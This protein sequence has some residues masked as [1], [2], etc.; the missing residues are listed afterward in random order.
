MEAS[1]AFETSVPIY[2]STWRNFTECLNPQWHRLENTKSRIFFVSPSWETN[3]S[4]SIHEITRILYN[5]KVSIAFTASSY[6][7]QNLSSTCHHPTSR[8]SILI[9]SS[10]L[11][12]GLPSGLFLQVSR[13]KLC[14][15]L[16]CPPYMLHT[17]PIWFFLISSPEYPSQQ[18]VPSD[19]QFKSHVL[20]WRRTT[21]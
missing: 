1:R 3:G 21:S 19:I 20:W 9:L 8:R 13:P 15:Q 6:P 2:Q 14:M 18:P 5:Q 17:V 12:S 10:D 4:S 16:S 11:R 7:E